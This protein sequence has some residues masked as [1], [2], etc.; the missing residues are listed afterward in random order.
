MCIFKLKEEL[1][2]SHTGN[3]KTNGSREF[4]PRD[5]CSGRTEKT[6]ETYHCHCRKEG[7]TETS[8][9]KQELIFPRK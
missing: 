2:G 6:Y 4:A 5:G 8:E 3:L 7:M 9:N 1:E